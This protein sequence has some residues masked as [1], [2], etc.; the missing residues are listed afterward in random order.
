MEML[1]TEDGASL[2]EVIRNSDSLSTRYLQEMPGEIAYPSRWI[3]V[4][5]R[6]KTGEVYIHK[7]I[8]AISQQ[9]LT[10]RMSRGGAS[11]ADSAALQC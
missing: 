1:K 11:G 10:K 3:G 9:T 4:D 7:C 6:F 8:N 2:K 5:L